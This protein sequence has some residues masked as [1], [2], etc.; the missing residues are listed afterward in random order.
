M[1]Q[2]I[3]GHELDTSGLAPQFEQYYQSKQRIEVQF[4]YGENVRGYV[5]K[6]TGWKPSYLLLLKSNS[7]GSSYLLGHGD[8]I[9]A[10]FNKYR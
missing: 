5:G 1:T 8:K 2:I 6:T 7:S 3:N 9:I 4:A 10:T